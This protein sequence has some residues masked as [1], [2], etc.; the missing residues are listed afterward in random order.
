MVQ[1]LVRDPGYRA[2]R[3]LVE[4]VYQTLLALHNQMINGTWY[5]STEPTAPPTW[6]DHDENGRH[7]FVCNVAVERKFDLVPAGD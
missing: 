5:L 7:I 1:V 4:R 2:A 6:L 3:R